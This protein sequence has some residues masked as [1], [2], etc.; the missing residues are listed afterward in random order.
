MTFKARAFE[1]ATIKGGTGAVRADLAEL[2]YRHVSFLRRLHGLGVTL[3]EPSDESVR[4]YVELWLPLVAKMASTGLAIIPP[5]DIAWI[6]HC[7]RLSTKLYEAYTVEQFGTNATATTQ[8]NGAASAFQ[9][10][11]K[12]TP[13]DL[14]QYSVDYWDMYNRGEPFF[15]EGPSNDAGVKNSSTATAS[16]KTK[17]ISLMQGWNGMDTSVVFSNSNDKRYNLFGFDLAA[18]SK[19]QASFLWNISGPDFYLNNSTVLDQAFLVQCAQNYELFLELELQAGHL[20]VP[21]HAIDL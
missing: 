21:T 2:S 19:N 6:W 16:M 18:C 17:M 4:R 7:H 3:T 20:L 12:E 1:I 13:R 10:L 5:T 11:T 8:L 14:K 15:V 9:F